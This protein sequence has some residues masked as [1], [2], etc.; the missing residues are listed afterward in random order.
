MARK[1]SPKELGVRQLEMD[2]SVKSTK[3]KSRRVRAAERS[4]MVET[5]NRDI[6]IFPAKTGVVWKYRG[7]YLYPQEEFFVEKLNGQKHHGLPAY[8]LL[9]TVKLYKNR[10]SYSAYEGV[11]VGISGRGKAGKKEWKKRGGR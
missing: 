2:L 7:S 9:H 11:I 10:K 8:R 4:V 5:D 6:K 1:R 3:R